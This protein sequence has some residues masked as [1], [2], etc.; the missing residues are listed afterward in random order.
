L[1]APSHN[2]RWTI[3]QRVLSERRRTRAA[4][5]PDA[6]PEEDDTETTETV[7]T[8]K[9]VKKNGNENEGENTEP[10]P[11]S[12]QAAAL[13]AELSLDHVRGWQS[14][15]RPFPNTGSVGTKNA[16]IERSQ[17]MTLEHER[18]S[19]VVSQLTR[20]LNQLRR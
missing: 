2:F 18:L 15:T 7:K 12:A 14:P 17:K 10:E 1:A 3:F 11:L 13:V 9:T 8:V 20:D 5:P 4:E 6:Q 19:D 16:F